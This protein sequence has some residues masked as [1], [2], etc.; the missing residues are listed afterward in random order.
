[1]QIFTSAIEM[2]E[3]VLGVQREGE[4]LG[5]VPTM[6]ALHAGHLRLVE[7]AQALCDRSVVSIFVN[8]AQ[9][10]PSE[11]L[12]SYPRNLDE[13]LRQLEKLGCW[14]VFAPLTDEMYPPGSETLVDVGS[15]AE[16]LEGVARPGHFQGVAT[17]VLKLFQIVPADRAFFGQKDYQQ[18]LVVGQMV[19]DLS[20]PIAIEVCPTVREPDGLAMSSRNAYLSAS[21]RQQALS[22]R[23]SLLL[24]EKLYAEGNCDVAPITEQMQRLLTSQPEV[25]IDYI[26]FVAAGTVQPVTTI[27]GPTVIAAVVRL[28][29]TRLLDNHQIG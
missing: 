28:G 22:L 11:D 6:G 9:F 2:R 10:G 18:T 26:S 1:M 19:R 17:I 7:A 3:A 27:S 15:V 4:T 25:E 29:Q 23:Q 21:Q 14:A 20:V 12:A 8:P 24:A 16:P 13:D 5:F